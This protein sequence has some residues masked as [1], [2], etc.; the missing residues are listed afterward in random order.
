M[1][2]CQAE[3]SDSDDHRCA[4]WVHGPEPIATGWVLLGEGGVRALQSHKYAIASKSRSGSKRRWEAA[5]VGKRPSRSATFILS[6]H[7]K[8]ATSA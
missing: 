5:S 2:Q 1:R 6:P 7:S 3:P 8:C 4:G